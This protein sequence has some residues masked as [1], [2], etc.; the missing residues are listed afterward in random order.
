M[1]PKQLRLTGQT[2]MSRARLDRIIDLNHPLAKLAGNS[3][4]ALRRPILARA[5]PANAAV[6]LCRRG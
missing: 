5:T 2:D 1:R 4:G 6:R 3:T